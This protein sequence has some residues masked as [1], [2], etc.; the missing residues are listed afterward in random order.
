MKIPSL[1]I[2]ITILRIILAPIIVRLVWSQQWT[3]AALLFAFAVLTDFLDGFVARR[4]HQE[5]R[6]GQL[7]DPIADKTLI[8]LLMYAL[9]LTNSNSSGHEMAKYVFGWFFIA[10][11]VILLTAAA[12]LY[13]RYEHFFKPTFFSRFVSV[14]EMVIIF[15][16]LIGRVFFATT[17]DMYS[18]ELTSGSW[19]YDQFCWYHVYLTMI[20]S[21]ALLLQY[22]VYVFIFLRKK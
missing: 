3:F 19:F 12:A 8:V 7:L 16:V 11:E 22:A 20:L 2:Q 10:K 15:E 14:S 18:L 4:Y 6:L 5:S 9:F 1:A 13:L 17:S 21:I